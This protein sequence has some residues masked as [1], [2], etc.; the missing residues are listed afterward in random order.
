MVLPCN[1][2]DITIGLLENDAA[3]GR[4]ENE[5]RDLLL[6]E[7]Q[8]VCFKQVFDRIVLCHQVR[9]FCSTICDSGFFKKGFEPDMGV[10]VDDFGG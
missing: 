5:R 8:S 7:H 3:A 2:A 1:L 4:A 10:D 9:P 6:R